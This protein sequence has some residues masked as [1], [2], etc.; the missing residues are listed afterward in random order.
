MP[1]LENS[2]EV[3]LSRFCYQSRIAT[4]VALW[5]SDVAL[6]YACMQAS[7]SK[8]DLHSWAAAGPDRNR[9]NVAARTFI[10]LHLGVI[11]CPR[12]QL[13]VKTARLQGKWDT[14]G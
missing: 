9:A 10:A 11:T 2:A 1:L 6:A 12:H 13:T 3:F 5:A 14:A 7:A 8:H 4:L